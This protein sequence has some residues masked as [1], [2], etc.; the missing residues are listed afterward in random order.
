MIATSSLSPGK[1]YLVRLDHDGDL[2]E[3]I[4][5]F[6]QDNGIRLGRVEAIGAVKTARIGYYDQQTREYQFQQLDRPMEI[7][8]LAGNVSLKDGE[9][10]VHAHITLA[11]ENGK[12]YGGHLA[13]GTVVFAC[14]CLV[15]ELVGDELNRGFDKQTGLPLW[16]S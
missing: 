5:G 14:E 9:P 2:I 8:K 4:T 12:A 13:T 7:L 16:E 15:Q 11:D 10:I 6:C 3:Q 1:S